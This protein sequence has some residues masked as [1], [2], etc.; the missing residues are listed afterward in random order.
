MRPKALLSHLADALVAMES[1]VFRGNSAHNCAMGGYERDPIMFARAVVR[2][3]ASIW[4]LVAT[5]IAVLAM[6]R[7]N[8]V[9]QKGT[10]HLASWWI[11]TCVAAFAVAVGMAALSAVLGA[12]LCKGRRAAR[13]AVMLLESVM[14]CF[15][16]FLAYLSVVRFAE[17]GSV[18]EFSAGVCGAFL[19]LTVVVRLLGKAARAYARGTAVQ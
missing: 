2:A 3:Q 18:I 16:V 13:V 9:Y 10:S 5:F 12:V 17:F 14:A 8:W 11:V 6:D 1:G 19:S 4:A 15:G 7:T